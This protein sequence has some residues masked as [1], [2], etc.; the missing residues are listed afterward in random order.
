MYIARRPFK[1]GGTVVPAG[2]VVEPAGI[3]RFRNL[4]YLGKIIEIHED[5]YDNWREA[6]EDRF[7]IKVPEEKKKRAAKKPAVVKDEPVE[8]QPVEKPVEEPA[9][10]AVEEVKPPVV[11]AKVTE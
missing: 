10:E 5:D 11:K 8:P 7:G 2:S 1:N 6:L 4:L 3:R 9:E